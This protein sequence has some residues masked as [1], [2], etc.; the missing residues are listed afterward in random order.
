MGRSGP[1]PSGVCRH[2]GLHHGSESRRRGRPWGRATRSRKGRERQRQSCATEEK[3]LQLP[4]HEGNPSSRRSLLAVRNARGVLGTFRGE[5]GTIRRGR[6]ATGNIPKP[7]GGTIP[8]RAEAVPVT[9]VNKQTIRMEHERRDDDVVDEG[10]TRGNIR[11]RRALRTGQ[12]QVSWQ[13]L[14]RGM[15]YKQNPHEGQA[16]SQQSPNVKQSASQ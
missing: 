4:K 10:S 9:E 11:G 6:R 7:R 15:P 16:S 3:A 8:T 13:R 12:Q 14:L 5:S 2:H 1:V